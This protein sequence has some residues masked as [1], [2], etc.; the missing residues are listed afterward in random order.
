[1][2]SKKIDNY[3]FL[4]VILFLS[5]LGSVLFYNTEPFA[6][7]MKK[8]YSNSSLP[9][10]EEPNQGLLLN[11]WYPVHKPSPQF[12][13][14]TQEQQYKNSPVFDSNSIQN[15]NIRHWKQP[16]NGE[17]S[18]PGICGNFYEDLPLEAPVK[19]ASPPLSGNDTPRVNYYTSTR[20]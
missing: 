15:N 8:S 16:T 4:A 14:E 18:P 11:G 9:V 7:Q 19:P 13:K 3:L 2:G 20:C 1:M 5:L 6:V 12:S 17:C 10:S